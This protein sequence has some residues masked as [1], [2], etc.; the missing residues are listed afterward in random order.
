MKGTMH[1][2]SS[3]DIKSILSAGVRSIPKVQRSA[4]LELYRLKREKDRIE[5]EI[6]AL[7]RRKGSANKRLASLYK[8]IGKLQKETREEQN[9]KTCRKPVDKSLRTVAIHY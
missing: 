9:M 3:R 4:Y 1:I 5:Q 2:T 8:R 7:D 6:F